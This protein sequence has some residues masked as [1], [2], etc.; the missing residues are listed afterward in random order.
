MTTLRQQKSLNRKMADW[1]GFKVLGIILAAIGIS[2]LSGIGDAI[3]GA[4]VL[5]LFVGGVA[6]WV[7][8]LLYGALLGT[9]V[10]GIAGYFNFVPDE[11]TSMRAFILITMWGGFVGGVVIGC[12]IGG[13]KGFVKWLD[14]TMKDIQ[15]IKQKTILL[16]K[17][18]EYLLHQV[19]KQKREL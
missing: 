10:G 5:G 8:G 15:E 9:I 2:F 7:E 11:S 17:K 19:E 14:T 4:I 18:V 16:E 12:V 3:I 13:I 1:V 6:N